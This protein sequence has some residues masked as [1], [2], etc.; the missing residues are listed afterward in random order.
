M[1]VNINIWLRCGLERGRGCLVLRPLS[2]PTVEGATKQDWYNIPV[3]RNRPVHISYISCGCTMTMFIRLLVSEIFPTWRHSCNSWGLQSE[4]PAVRV[5]TDMPPSPLQWA[6]GL[7]SR[8][9][10]CGWWTRLS[11]P[12][13]KTAEISG[14][15]CAIG[16]VWSTFSEGRP[17]HCNTSQK[18]Y[19]G[20]EISF[21]DLQSKLWHR[22]L[23]LAQQQY[24][25]CFYSWKLQLRH[26]GILWSFTFK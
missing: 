7:S 21:H 2:A 22:D 11:E 14:W 15:V 16:A 3:S 17:C 24:M 13:E 26:M 5:H 20:G 1:S 6:I 18:R 12:T 19:F 9:L 10:C 23:L 25:L 8:S 4:L